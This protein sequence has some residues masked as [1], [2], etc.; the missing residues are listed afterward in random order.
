MDVIVNDERCK[1]KF[2]IL[3]TDDAH[4]LYEKYGFNNSDKLISA[5]I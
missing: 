3:A 5:K 4:T 1:G 2:L